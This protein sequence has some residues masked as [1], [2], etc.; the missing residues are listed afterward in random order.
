VIERADAVAAAGFPGTALLILRNRIHLHLTEADA[1]GEESSVLFAM[2]PHYR[3]IGREE[4]ASLAL[5][6]GRPR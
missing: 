2:A 5:A 6:M 1:R 4:Y 3:A